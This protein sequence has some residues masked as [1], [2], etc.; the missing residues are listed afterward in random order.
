MCSETLAFYR[1]PSPMTAL[2]DS[3]TLADMP[4][5]LDGLRSLVQGLLLH[6]EWAAAYGV[7]AGAVR[8][9]EQNLRSAAEVL[10]RAFEISAEPVVAAR[11]PAERVVG[12]CWHFAVL[13]AAL[14]RAGGS[15]ARVRCGFA[16]YFD[17]AKWYD[18]WIIERWDGEHW[19]RDDPQID[20][21]QAEALNLDFDPHDQPAGRFLTAGEAWQAARDRRGRR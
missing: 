14:L 13:Y 6:R 16:G 20:A 1:S 10:G 9:D 19:I 7:E 5:A 11:Q 17:A 21:V 3:P 4:V 18:H 8:V 12:I 15:P 2:P